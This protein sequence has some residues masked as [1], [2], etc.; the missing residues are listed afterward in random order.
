M[1]VEGVVASGF[2]PVREYL[3]ENED[4]LLGGGCALA[5]TLEGAPVVDIW[6][7]MA[8][9]DKAWG[10]NT[11][12]VLMSATKAA[13]ATCLAVLADRGKLDV[14][15]PAATYWPEFAAAGKAQITVA[16]LLDHS[17]GT[18]TIPD[19]ESLLQWDGSGWSD[20]Q[21]IE[22]RLAGAA[23]EWEPGS[24]HGYHGLT[25]G[26]AWDALVRRIDGRSL[27]EFFREE[28][29]DPLNL[30][31]SIGT[32]SEDFKRVAR[33][34]NINLDELA[35]ELRA[36]LEPLLLNNRDPAH[37]A[38]KAFMAR[39]GVGALDRLAEL[40]NNP[41]VLETEVPAG[42][43]TATARGLARFH[44]M[45][46]GGGTLEGVTLLSP[47]TVARFTAE[48]RTEMD[49]VLGMPT[50]RG[51]GFFLNLV[52]GP[53]GRSM[54]PTPS[55]FGHSGAGG[56]QGFADPERKVSVGFVRNHLTLEP[57][58]GAGLIARVYEC[59]DN[60]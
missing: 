1:S 16:Q 44:A 47:E 48:R 38:G 57:F 36:V 7:G 32:A 12:A 51:L 18:I 10:E 46:A 13:A 20:I 37:F 35:P 30:D 11:R 19:Y 40:M 8:A 27:G 17:A 60:A 21:E 41:R 5:V 42:N 22:R 31:F 53:L 14:E 24:C 34:R 3:A 15:A 25:C 39:E 6:S 43:G 59:L 26:W 52:E 45:L 55:A 29:A 50:S 54:G 28:I 2:E 9:P 4:K 58:F 33:V 23:P 49:T 56:Q